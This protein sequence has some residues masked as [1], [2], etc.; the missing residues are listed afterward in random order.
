MDKH[1]GPFEISAI[2]G[3]ARRRLNNARHLL[4][5]IAGAAV[6]LAI[7]GTSPAVLAIV[8]LAVSAAALLPRPQPPSDDRRSPTVDGPSAIS[9]VSGEALASR[10]PDPVI[11]F[12]ADGAI[13]SAN[14]AARTAFGVLSS[15]SLLYL[16]F[17]TRE[18]HALIERVV[19]T[20]QTSAIEYYERVPMERWYQT[21][22]IALDTGTSERGLFLLVFRDQSEVRRTDRMR[23]DFVANASH[24][25]RTPLASLSGFIE[26]LRGPARNDEA[27]RERFLE[28]MQAQADRMARLIDDLL[29]LSRIEMKAHIAPT[30]TVDLVALLDHVS[31]ALQPLA[32]EMGVSIERNMPAGPVNVT[33]ERDELMQVFENLVENACKYGQ[34]GKRVLVELD[35]TEDGPRV[36]V[37]DLGPG[38]PEEHIPRLTERF[39]RVDVETSRSQKGTGLGLAI[40]KHILTRH[41]ARL[42]I[43]SRVGQGA[44]FAVQF[45][46]EEPFQSDASRFRQ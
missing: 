38:I 32:R 21:T 23:Q 33:G 35:R 42:V 40:V 41:R 17:R 18:M 39:Y 1:S 14:R 37:R 2:L 36:T 26:T 5:A 10:L 44:S 4:L 24:E 34:E 46:C 6:V 13:L 45:A 7:F 29:S 20:G 43:R 11:F 3:V 31:D 12:D 15:G 22:A 9:R 19:A 25:L 28:I 27:A 30:G 8:F 16:R